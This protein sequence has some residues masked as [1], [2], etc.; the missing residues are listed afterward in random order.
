VGGATVGP[1]KP[2]LDSKRELKFGLENT[3]V[4]AENALAETR[5]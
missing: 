3:V 1:G 5:P 4:S 2:P